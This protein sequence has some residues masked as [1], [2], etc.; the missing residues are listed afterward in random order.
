MRHRAHKIVVVCAYHVRHHEYCLLWSH[1]GRQGFSVECN[2]DLV[3]LQLHHLR[4]Q[5][6]EAEHKGNF[7]SLFQSNVVATSQPACHCV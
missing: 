6:D 2:A 3:L 7:V 1:F 4:K 5:I